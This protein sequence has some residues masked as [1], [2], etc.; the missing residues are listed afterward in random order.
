M[1]RLGE[2]LLKPLGIML[3][4]LIVFQNGHHQN[5]RQEHFQHR[6]IDNFFNSA[7]EI[8]KNNFFSHKFSYNT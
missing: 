5:G 6:E 8:A 1:Q 3:L 4:K 7:Y 2:G